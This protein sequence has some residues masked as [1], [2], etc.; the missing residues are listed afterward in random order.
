MLLILCID[1]HKN[2]IGHLLKLG[3]EMLINGAEVSR[4]EDALKR[5]FFSYGCKNVD[6]FV[7]TSCIILTV[8]DNT[9]ESFTRTVRITS[10][11]TDFDRLTKLN[12]LSRHICKNTPEADE[13]SN[14]LEKTLENTKDGKSAFYKKCVGSVLASGAF[15]VFFGGHITDLLLAAFVAVCVS[16]FELFFKKKDSNIPVYYFLCT[17]FSGVLTICLCRLF[18]KASTDMI[19]IGFIMLVIPGLAFTN[20]ARDFLLG[21]TITGALRMLESVLQAAFIAGGIALSIIIMRG[22]V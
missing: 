7:V 8:T 22:A 2:L 19:M 14:L 16:L 3:E 6:V 12:S 18:G 9:G 11:K 5:L 20:A 21:D 1:S 17:L 13:V 15:A 4:V 10:G